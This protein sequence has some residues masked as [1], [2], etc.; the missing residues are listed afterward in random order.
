VAEIAGRE[1]G[2]ALGGLVFVAVLAAILSTLDTAMNAGALVL[3]R[4]IINQAFPHA[5]KRPVPWARAATVIMALLAFLIA[6][7]FRNILKT[8]GLSSEIMA[9]G[10][11]VPGAAMLVLRD[12]RP[13]AGLLGIAFGGGFAVLSFL[14]AAGIVPLGLPVWPHSVPYGLALGATGF[15]LGLSIDKRRDRSRRGT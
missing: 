2:F 3:N 5:R 7:K 15:F 11:F 6:L 9:E 14:G 8:I 10:F 12:K 4:D 1:A 13:L